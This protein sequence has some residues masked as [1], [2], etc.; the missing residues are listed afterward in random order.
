MKPGRE[1]DAM[2][3]EKVMGCKWIDGWH[4]STDIQAAWHV[5]EK[6]GSKSMVTIR[7]GF[8]HPQGSTY[9]HTETTVT[10][11][12]EYASGISAPHAICLAALKAVEIK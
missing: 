5:V 7:T 12:G 4:P 1:L 8:K 10:V 9:H 2:V 11:G 6:L 3:S